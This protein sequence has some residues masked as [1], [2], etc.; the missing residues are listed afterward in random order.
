MTCAD[1]CPE[2]G[3]LAGGGYD[4]ARRAAY[5]HEDYQRNPDKYTLF[6]TARIAEAIPGMPEL[7]VGQVVN[8]RYFATRLNRTRGNFVMPVYQ[9]WTDD[10]EQQKKMPALLYACCLEG[11]VL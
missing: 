7:G 8:I 6:R 2:S 3:N 1:S 10:F 5:S 9:V 11:F 4:L